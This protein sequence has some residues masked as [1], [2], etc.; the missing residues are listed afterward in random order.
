MELN[1]VVERLLQITKGEVSATT[2]D[3]DFADSLLNGKY[4]FYQRGFLTG[5]QMNAAIRMVEKID[6]PPPVEQ[7]T[8]LEKV[9]TFFQDARKHLKFP[10]I[11][12]TLG[13]RQLKVYMSG[14]RSN[15]P[16]TVNL[17]TEDDDGY[18]DLWLGRVFADGEWQHRKG[19]D[20][21]HKQA[22]VVL[23]AL[24]ADPAKVAAEHGHLTG[25]CCFC[26]R[27]LTDE[28]S[29]DVGYGPVCATRW[30]LPWGVASNGQS[31][32]SVTQHQFGEVIHERSF[33][34]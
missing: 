32:L 5:N 27:K 2:R 21:L 10:K 22:A 7:I 29:T 16:D 13:S 3:V 17:V 26:N 4:G 14:S 15:H 12:L 20:A 33:C 9:Y 23:T 8:N 34:G 25:N 6:N 18:L 31:N 19:H 28:R 30:S 11:M 1:E 24:A